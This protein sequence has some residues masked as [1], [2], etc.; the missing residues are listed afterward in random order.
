MKLTPDEAEVWIYQEDKKDKPFEAK[1]F[2]WARR[3]EAYL[4]YRCGQFFSEPY[5][6]HHC[7]HWSKGFR[8]LMKSLENCHG[9]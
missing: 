2:G 6:K 7:E 4:H 1:F 5:E 8:K 9:A 3:K